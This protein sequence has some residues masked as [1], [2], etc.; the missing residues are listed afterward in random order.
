MLSVD[1]T[2]PVT[3]A[4][5]VSIHDVEIEPVAEC[6][7]LECIV[8]DTVGLMLLLTVEQPEVLTERDLPVVTEFENVAEFVY[9]GDIVGECV[10][11]VLTDAVSHTDIL[12]DEDTL[13]E[14]DGEN[15]VESEGE[16]DGDDDADDVPERLGLIVAVTDID[17]SGLA[18]VV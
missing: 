18:E 16:V 3:E 2:E 6:D 8:R 12:D 5:T 4:V 11:V 15:D 9:D 1:V 10:P 7:A 17:V 13:G 14:P